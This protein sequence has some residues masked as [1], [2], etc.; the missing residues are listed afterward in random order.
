MHVVSLTDHEMAYLKNCTSA[1]NAAASNNG[2]E[3]LVRNMW[4]V[5]AD[6]MSRVQSDSDDFFPPVT[7]ERAAAMLGN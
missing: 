1:P 2:A 7:A 4:D 6:S 3:S 5:C